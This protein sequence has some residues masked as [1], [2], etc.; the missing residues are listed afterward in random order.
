[1]IRDD[2]GR[3]ARHRLEDGDAEP[4][5]QRRVN[6]HVGTPVERG[7]RVGGD[8]ARQDDAGVV[9]PGLLAPAGAA[10][11]HEPVLASEQAPGLDEPVQVLARLERPDAEDVRP[12][13]ERG[14]I[15]SGANSSPTP[16]WATTSRSGSMPSVAVASSAVYR[17]FVKTT[18][19]CATASASLRRC[20]A[21]VRGVHHSG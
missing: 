15:P 16:G 11:E 3:A 20:I 18:S 2:D 17:E 21:I 12:P 19:Q 4:L 10:R 5:E 14:T 6:E 7:Q 1:M 8:V 13:V 9:E